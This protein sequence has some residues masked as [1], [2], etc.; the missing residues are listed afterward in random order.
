MSVAMVTPI[1]AVLAKA[2]GQREHDEVGE[3]HHRERNNR[4]LD[5]SNGIIRR[6]SCLY[7]AGAMNAHT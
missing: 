7:S 2:E 5:T 3:S 4:L 1:G 6:R